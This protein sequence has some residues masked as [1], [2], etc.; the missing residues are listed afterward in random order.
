MLFFI[1]LTLCLLKHFIFFK[2]ILMRHHNRHNKQTLKKHFLAVSKAYSNCL[3]VTYYAADLTLN[4][5][6]LSHK[7]IQP[8]PVDADN[9]SKNIKVH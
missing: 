9:K 2:L 8:L 7:T 6:W 3:N 1:I 5:L 4:Y